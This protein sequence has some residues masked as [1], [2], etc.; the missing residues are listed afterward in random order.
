MRAEKN[1]NQSFVRRNCHACKR[2]HSPFC[3]FYSRYGYRN[4]NYLPFNRRFTISFDTGTNSNESRK[5]FMRISR[6]IC[7]SLTTRKHTN[8]VR[9]CCQCCSLDSR[10]VKSKSAA[11][12]SKR[13]S[14]ILPV[15]LLS[16]R[17][18]MT[19]AFN[20]IFTNRRHYDRE[21]RDQRT[22]QKTGLWITID[23]DLMSNMNEWR[24]RMSGDLLLIHDNDMII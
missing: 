20:P 10:L 23:T 2:C 24:L 3:P 6:P 5:V 4:N 21:R 13:I 8:K 11:K 18:G 15:C 12:I 16:V 14:C 9:N 22:C 1:L 17:R 7:M 19:Q